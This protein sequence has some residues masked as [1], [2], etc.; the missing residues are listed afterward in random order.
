MQKRRDGRCGFSVNIERHSRFNEYYKTRLR[1]L[2]KAPE[3]A[4]IEGIYEYEPTLLTSSTM[5]FMF[6]RETEFGMEWS[7]EKM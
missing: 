6:S 4:V 2:I 1:E 5:A 3:A 7:E